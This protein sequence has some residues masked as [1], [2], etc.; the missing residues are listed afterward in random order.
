MDNTRTIRVLSLCYG[1]GGLELAL[2]RL[3]PEAHFRV[4]AVEIEAYAIANACQNAKASKMDLMAVY[5]DVKSFPAE[6]FRGCFDIVIGGYPCQPFSN[7]GKQ[8]ASEDPRH[9]WPYIQNILR[10]IRPVCAFFENVRGHVKL[11]LFDVVR[12]LAELGYVSECGIFS[13]EEVGASHRRERLFIV[14]YDDSFI[15]GGLALRSACGQWPVCADSSGWY[16][17]RSKIKLGCSVADTCHE[18]LQGVQLGSGF[19]RKRSA[20]F[21]A[22]AEFRAVARPGQEQFSWEKPRTIKPGMGR[23]ADGCSCWVDRIR[24]LGN[25]VF[26]LAAGKAFTVLSDKIFKECVK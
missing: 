23:T 25:G 15:S 2:E 9:L 18:R 5:S 1:Y 13:A 22:V 10:E 8:L 7:A 21:G 14:A 26:P 24:L 6:R 12:D 11:G 3:F 20:S 4:V 16:P 19:G 17:I